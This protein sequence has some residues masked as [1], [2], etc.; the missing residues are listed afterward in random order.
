MDASLH[1]TSFEGIREVNLEKQIV[2][3]KL[4]VNTPIFTGHES[5]IT[6]YIGCKKDVEDCCHRS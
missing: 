1:T 3:I 4:Q 5:Q 6:I 2:M